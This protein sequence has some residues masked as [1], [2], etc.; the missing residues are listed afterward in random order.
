MTS[1][2]NGL[3]DALA[4]PRGVAISAA[5]SALAAVMASTVAV[6]AA[7]IAWLAY[8]TQRRPEKPLL[9][10]R[11]RPL[12]KDGLYPVWVEATNLSSNTLELRR[13]VLV[14]PK[15]GRLS[16][17]FESELG[18]GVNNIIRKPVPMKGPNIHLRERI[19]G[20]GSTK[21]GRMSG[22]AVARRDFTPALP[23]PA[24][25]TTVQFYLSL[26]PDTRTVVLEFTTLVRTNRNR[27]LR[28]RVQEDVPR[29]GRPPSEPAV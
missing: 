5:A 19:K 7:L 3:V 11:I 12:D 17:G 16:R 21:P 9:E 2:W 22:V 6:V 27:L 24:D 25:R 8:R 28:T 4:S 18:P 29:Q 26:P 14:R 1:W 15:K 10:V 20:A 23:E 13:I